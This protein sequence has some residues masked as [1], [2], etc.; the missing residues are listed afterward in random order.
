M[1]AFGV[2]CFGDAVGVENEQITGLEAEFAVSR[3]FVDGQLRAEPHAGV[4]GAQDLRA[5]DLSF[6]DPLVH[7]IVCALQF[8]R[9]RV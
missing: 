6:I 9:T 8:S 4:R 7:T 1:F 5:M 2:E 3:G